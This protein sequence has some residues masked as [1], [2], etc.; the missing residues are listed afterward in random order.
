MPPRHQEADDQQ[1]LVRWFGL[2]YPQYKTLL[3]AFKN[4]WARP[5]GASDEWY[6]KRGGMALAMGVRKGT[7]DLFLAVPKVKPEPVKFGKAKVFVPKI[8]HGL[9]IELKPTPP[10][11]RQASKAQKEQM[12]RLEAQGYKVA[13][14]HGWEAAMKEIKEY[15]G[16]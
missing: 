8:Y 13:L 12:A 10:P 3:M 9:F 6:R 14:C 4:E 15:L 1:A 11:K 16:N 5:P 2:Q 7:P